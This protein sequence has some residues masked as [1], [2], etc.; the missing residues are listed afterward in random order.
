MTHHGTQSSAQ[1]QN[2]YF[3]CDA[4]GWRA[5]WG[6]M[7]GDGGAGGE[8]GGDDSSRPVLCSQLGTELPRVCAC[9][10][11]RRLPSRPRGSGL[12]RLYEYVM[13]KKRK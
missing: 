5:S 1:F 8:G 6:A 11:V 2:G 13:T 4:R 12:Q 9:M 3:A 7:G 10:G